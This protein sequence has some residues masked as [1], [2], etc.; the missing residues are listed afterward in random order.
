MKG[1]ST[2]IAAIIVAVAD[3]F[4]VNFFTKSCAN[5]LE[6]YIPAFLAGFYLW[7]KRIGRGGIN[8][9]GFRK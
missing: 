3:P 5:E 9:I 4:L 1:F 7:V 8:K 2:E 6:A